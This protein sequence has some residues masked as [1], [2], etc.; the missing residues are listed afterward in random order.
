MFHRGGLARKVWANL[1]KSEV[2]GRYSGLTGNLQHSG[3][4]D[5]DGEFQASVGWKS[6]VPLERRKEE[7]KEG[8]QKK[9]R[10]EGKHRHILVCLWSFIFK[11]EKVPVALMK[12][13]RFWEHYVVVLVRFH[14]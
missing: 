12:G 9:G 3:D 5:Q 4:H 7:E 14:C 13:V 10:E 11:T 1:F 2:S 8:G 6:N